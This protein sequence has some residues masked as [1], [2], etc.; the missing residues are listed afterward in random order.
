MDSSDMQ[1]TKRQATGKDE[2]IALNIEN[3]HRRYQQGNDVLEVLNGVNLKIMPGEM[4]GLLVYR[5]VNS[6]ELPSCARLLMCQ[7]SS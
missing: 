6:K 3:I 4:V 5:V 1:L 2:K 7:E